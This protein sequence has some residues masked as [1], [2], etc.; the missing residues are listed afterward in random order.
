MDL[1]WRWHV[2]HQEISV[3]LTES[4]RV[5]FAH[6]M[7]IYIHRQLHL[8]Y[9]HLGYVSFLSTCFKVALFL[10]ET[11]LYLEMKDIP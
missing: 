2:Y 9:V 5:I 1:D 8:G 6:A 11:S 10:T 4:C 7:L 3:I